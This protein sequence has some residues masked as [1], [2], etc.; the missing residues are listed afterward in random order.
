MDEILWS[1][2]KLAD[3]PLFAGLW[4]ENS[5]VLLGCWLRTRAHSDPKIEK[6]LEQN[7]MLMAGLEAIR[8][9]QMTVT[10]ISMTDQC[11]SGTTFQVTSS[12]E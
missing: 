10:F 5:E 9:A 12:T 3:G 4:G 1:C 8:A 7:T 6:G 11:A 2:A